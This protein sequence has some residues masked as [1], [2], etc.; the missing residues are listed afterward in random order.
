[1]ADNIQR[2]ASDG[3]GG[4][5]NGDAFGQSNTNIYGDAS[6]RQGDVWPRYRIR[7]ILARSA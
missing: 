3:T 4:T 1:M 6:M 5:E 7:P 2:A